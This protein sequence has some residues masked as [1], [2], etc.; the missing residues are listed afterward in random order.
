ME[1]SG[2]LCSPAS[3]LPPRKPKRNLDVNM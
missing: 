2:H 1:V 3:L